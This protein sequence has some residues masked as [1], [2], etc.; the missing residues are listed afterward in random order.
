MDAFE[1]SDGTKNEYYP[2]RSQADLLGQ[3]FRAQDSNLG[4]IQVRST[5]VRVVDA[6]TIAIDR[7]SYLSETN[8]LGS[9]ID[10]IDAN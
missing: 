3:R 2:S 10:L 7:V 4:E 9:P 5:V 8:V 1:Y 6:Q